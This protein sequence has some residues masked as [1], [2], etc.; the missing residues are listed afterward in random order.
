MFMM[1]DTD[2]LQAMERMIN[3]V[4]RGYYIAGKD[5][6]KL[7]NEIFNKELPVTNCSSCIRQ[8]FAELRQS[9]NNYIESQKALETETVNEIQDAPIVVK[10]T[11]KITK[12]KAKTIKKIK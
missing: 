6:T 5:V 2:Q 10:Q 9:Y 8:R 3:I 7:Y 4:K 11:K 12:P 1:W